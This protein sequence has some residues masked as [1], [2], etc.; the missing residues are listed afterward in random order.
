MKRYQAVCLVG[1]LALSLGAA[2]AARAGRYNAVRTNS[3]RAATMA[4]AGAAT[5][6]VTA[7]EGSDGATVNLFLPEVAHINVGDTVRWHIAGS[8]EQ[9]DIAFGPF[10]A[11]T[12][13]AAQL[14][15]PVPQKAGPPLLA[16]NPQVAG[17]TPQTT[18]DGS[19]LVHSAI[20]AD[21]QTYSLTFTKPGTYRYYCLIHFPFMSGTVVVSPRPAAPRYIVT[22]GYLDRG[23]GQDAGQFYDANFGPS[24][25]TVHAGDSVTWVLSS[26]VPHTIS[27]GPRGLLE[28]L[29]ARQ[30]VPARGKDGQTVLALNPRITAPAGG[31]TY[32]GGYLNSGLLF[33][34]PGQT[35]TFSVTFPKSGDYYYRCLIHRGMDGYIHV[36]PA[37]SM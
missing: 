25:L 20:L 28:R 12:T 32:R 14:I 33:P 16:F 9:H 13:L 5:W 22:A 4:M 29:A 36:L 6:E 37:G 27:F 26:A 3:H 17:P 2:Q 23:A 11:L 24:E 7:G 8:I 18:Y 35:L 34:R 31:T 10:A 21:G 1:T 15:V 30:V 19:A